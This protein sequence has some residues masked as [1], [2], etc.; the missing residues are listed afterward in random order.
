MTGL[1]VPAQGKA[2]NEAV[3]VAMYEDDCANSRE[4]LNP[5]VSASSLQDKSNADRSLPTCLSSPGRD[6]ADSSLPVKHHEKASSSEQAGAI[7]TVERRSQTIPLRQML[8]LSADS[9]TMVRH[10]YGP[11]ENSSQCIPTPSIKTCDNSASASSSTTTRSHQ[12][13]LLEELF[14]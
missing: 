14:G 11:T 1:S 10:E 6:H 13:S 9:S 5:G 2:P 8:E 4:Q 3:G 7:P 12:P